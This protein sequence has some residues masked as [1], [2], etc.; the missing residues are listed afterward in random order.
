[1][2]EPVVKLTIVF[3]EGRQNS[4]DSLFSLMVRFENNLPPPSLPDLVD[5]LTPRAWLEQILLNLLTTDR[6]DP[7]SPM[8]LSANLLSQEIENTLFFDQARKFLQLVGHKQGLGLTARGSLNRASVLLKCQ[9][10]QWADM[11]RQVNQEMGFAEYR[12]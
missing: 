7:R 9:H 4:F 10:L 12:R 3:P 11:R 1:M 8:K 2:P 5:Q 6:D